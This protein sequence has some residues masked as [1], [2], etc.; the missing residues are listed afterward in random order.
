MNSKKFNIKKKINTLRIGFLLIFSIIFYGTTVLIT[1]NEFCE[2]NLS[3]KVCKTAFLIT[4][5]SYFIL[6]GIIQ[7]KRLIAN[8]A[9]S[10]LIVWD[11]EETLDRFKNLKYGF[12]FY[13]EKGSRPNAG[14]LLLARADPKRNGYPSIE[15]WDINMQEKIHFYD[16]KLDDIYKKANIKPIDSESFKRPILLKDGS[17]I[18]SQ[19]GEEMALIKLD[20]CGKLI[21]HNKLLKTHHSLEA[22]SEGNIYT[23]ILLDKEYVKDNKNL[24]P[25]NYTFDGFMIFDEDLKI[26]ETFSLLDIYAKNNLLGDV[27]DYGSQEITSDVFHVNDVEPYIS[28]EGNKYV[29]ISHLR[30]SRVMAVSL[31]N[32]NV[33]WFLERATNLQHD[34]DVL[35]EYDNKI[36]ISIFDNNNYQ[37]GKSY[38]QVKQR[39]NRIAYL[40]NLPLDKNQKTFV[41]GD[42]IQYEKFKLNYLN[43]LSLNKKFRPKTR[44]QGLVDH[45]MKNNSLMVE[46]TDYGRLIELEQNTNK[47]LWQYYNKDENNQP[48]MI[49]WSR[50]FKSLPDGL[51]LN[52]FKT[53]KNYE[54]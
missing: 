47:I 12:N 11:K 28:A 18:V 49:S 39:G 4:K 31:D 8:K 1:K 34:V 6:D 50:R 9:T 2:D 7:T 19:V 13:Y 25:E 23:A 52:V 30:N 15:L 17:I 43:F 35:R 29:F 5:P 41:I 32:L 36:D 54:D 27:Y 20:K 44:T 40:Q 46:E 24:H 26:L 51:D 3:S 48:Y 16:I 38:S 33:L 22:D 10:G 45:I 42:E 21:G 53:C 37:F 14:Y